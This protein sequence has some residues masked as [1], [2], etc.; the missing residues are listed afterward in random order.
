MAERG[1]KIY[2]FSLLGPL[3][4]WRGTEEVALGSPQQRAVLAMLLLRRGHTVAVADL[5]DGVWGTEPPQGA[6]SVVR[7][8]ISRL[9][10]LLEPERA[11]GQSPG[12][13]LSIGDG[14]VMATD[15]VACDVTACDAAVAQA[16]HHRAA[17][18]GDLALRLLATALA[19]WGTPALAGVPGPYAESARTDL[20]E[21]RLGT[22][23]LKLRV[24]LEIGR[25]EAAVAELLAMRDAHPLRE[26]VSEL[27]LVALYRCGRQAEALEAYARTRRTLVDELGIEPGPSL[28]GLHARLLAGDPALAQ[29]IPSGR[30]GGDGDGDGDTPGTPDAW[31]TRTE[32]GDPGSPARRGDKVRPSQL[33]ADLAM[34]TG[35]RS[36][37]VRVAALLPDDGP[38]SATTAGTAT[39]ATST[40]IAVIDGMAGAGK[41]TLAVHWAHRIAHRFPDGSLYVNLR[42]WDPGGSR[43]NS[44]EALET[45]LVALGVAPHAVPEGLDAQ[46]ALY[47][48]V[49]SDRRVLIVLD[50]ARD[51]EHIQPLLPGAS[52]CLVIVTSRGR[53]S[54]LVARHGAHPLTLGLLSAEESRELLIR[55]LGSARVDAEPEAADAIVDLCARLPLALSIAAARAA[56]HPGFRLADIAAELRSDHGSLDAFAAGQDAGSDARAVFSWSY[57][58]LSP[59]AAGL[60]RRLSVHPG[61][62]ISTAVAVALAGMPRRQ[63]RALLTELTGASLL[64]ERVPS[65]FVF[66]DLLRAY[67]HELIT[68]QHSMYERDT[69]VLRLLDHYL[70][71]AHQASAVLDPF[72]ETIPLPPGSTDSEPLRFNDGKQATAWLRTERHVL[73]A[74]VEYAADDG[75][76]NHAWRTAYALDLYF[77]RLG[78]RH[79]LMEIN[80]AALRAAC[81]L[82]DPVGQAHALRSL[83]FGHTRFGHPDEALR[84]LSRALDLFQRAGD[85]FGQARTHRCLA[86]LA[87][88]TGRYVDSLDHYAQAGELY[89]SLGHHGGEAS[90]LNEIGWTYILLGDAERALEHCEKSVSL[91]QEAADLNGEASA[92][93]S[94]GY[95][96]HHL[97]RYDAAVKRFE[98][99]VDLYQ[100]LGNRYLEADTLRH[101]GDSHRAAGDHGPARTAWAAAL[102]LL[103]E[104][105]HT[106]ADEVR[107]SLRELTQG[108]EGGPHR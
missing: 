65:R 74:I 51:T 89:R 70:H 98:L 36:E 28:R 53:L 10:K 106:E 92:Q 94:V 47:R 6:V 60:F 71:T 38:A 55:R 22:M 105:G 73:R 57:N 12:I 75:H 5:V 52:G 4:A 19:T 35:R 37:L 17:G 30:A 41:T 58:A 50:N 1:L 102:A 42:G 107:Q 9:R 101:L 26:S 25:H 100:E 69:T 34:F 24:E 31:D 80:K 95:A 43:M 21:R 83:G 96:H 16:T 62:D 32:S 40:A 39:T 64:M 49:L 8:Y 13:L 93:D 7:T 23:E 48:S 77:D 66:H 15:T 104:G 61:P 18:E 108:D 81:T 56:H 59:E 90:V 103:E 97:G 67:A 11:P 68:N 91:H 2:R 84:L 87:N 20:A 33:P 86:Y 27:L 88:E 63:V 46:A 72:R 76:H 3:R 82:G 14:Y 85:A 29:P 99:A 44:G 79:D 45:F 54:G 78:Y